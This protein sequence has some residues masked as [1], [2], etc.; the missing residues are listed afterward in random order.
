MSFVVPNTGSRAGADVPQVH[1]RDDIGS[2]TTPVR[3]LVDFEKVTREPA[4]SRRVSIEIPADALSLWN[5]E[6]TLVVEPGRFS[7]MVAAS[8]EDVRWHCSF[9]VQAK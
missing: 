7:A 1:L 6:M 2:V 8:A 5:A 9:E 4:E 3:K